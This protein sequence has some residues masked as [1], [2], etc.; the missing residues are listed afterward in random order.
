MYHLLLSLLT[1]FLFENVLNYLEIIYIELLVSSN[2]HSSSLTTTAKEEP[3]VLLSFTLNYESIDNAYCEKKS[4]IN[5]Q[6]LSIAKV[7]DSQT[8]GYGEVVIRK[9][10]QR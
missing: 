9:K 1:Q 3:T 5:G 6:Y 2:N 4:M 10:I 7:R 8:N